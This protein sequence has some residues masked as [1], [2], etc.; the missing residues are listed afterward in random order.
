MDKLIEILTWLDTSNVAYL[1]MI[2]FFIGLYKLHDD[3]VRENKRLR[4]LLRNAVLEN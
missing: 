4:R 3:V 2:A 1:L